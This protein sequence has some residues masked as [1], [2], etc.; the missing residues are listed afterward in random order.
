MSKGFDGFEDLID[1]NTGIYGKDTAA[2]SH[3]LHDHDARELLPREDGLGLMFTHEPCGMQQVV[4]IDWQEVLALS[5]GLSP[6]AAFGTRI[7]PQEASLIE[8][9]PAW[10]AELSDWKYTD[11]GTWALS[12]LRCRVSA[13]PKREIVLALTPSEAV[14]AA[15]VAQAQRFIK[16][17]VPLTKWAQQVVGMLRRRK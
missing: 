1:S 7:N 16:D 13:C 4:V 8:R 9:Y 5:M 15:R 14:E 11:R 3:A 10:G 12:G 17:E 6:R 2:L